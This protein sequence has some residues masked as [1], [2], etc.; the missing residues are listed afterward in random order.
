MCTFCKKPWCGSGSLLK[1]VLGLQSE[2]SGKRGR[3]RGSSFWS[4]VRVN[5]LSN[6][7]R[8]IQYFLTQIMFEVKEQLWSVKAPL[9]WFKQYIRVWSQMRSH[10]MNKIRSCYRPFVFR[11]SKKISPY[12]LSNIKTGHKQSNLCCCGGFVLIDKRSLG[13]QHRPPLAIIQPSNFGE[14]F[15]N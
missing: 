15:L 7:W 13:L 10:K 12:R 8:K 14:I 9:A 1:N 2:A 3:R 5:P 4:P 11:C 6:G